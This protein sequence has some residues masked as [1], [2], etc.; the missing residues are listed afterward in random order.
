MVG[1]TLVRLTLSFFVV[2]VVVH[3]VHVGTH[4]F[5]FSQAE[6]NS[7]VIAVDARALMLQ[8]TAWGNC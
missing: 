5:C 7:E 2:W 1:L 8:S 6:K 3:C 4:L